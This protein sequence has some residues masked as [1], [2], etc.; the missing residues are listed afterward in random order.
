LIQGRADYLW[1]GPE[2]Q[3]FHVWLNKQLPQI[4][5]FQYSIVNSS[6]SG[7]GFSWQRTPHPLFSIQPGVLYLIGNPV[8][9]G[10]G[11]AAVISALYE[12]EAFHRQSVLPK[13]K[14]LFCLK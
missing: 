11:P 14:S 4:F 7:L 5:N 6:L 3:G 12:R 8:K 9:I 10:S 2:G 1:P 13:E